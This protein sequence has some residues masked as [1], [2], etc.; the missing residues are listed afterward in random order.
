MQ[1]HQ[2]RGWRPTRGR[3]TGRPLLGPWPSA[4]TPLISSAGRALGFTWQAGL[5]P[6]IW[7]VGGGDPLRLDTYKSS[8]LSVT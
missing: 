1:V 8:L 2:V 4:H 7:Q 5:W 6:L 3:F